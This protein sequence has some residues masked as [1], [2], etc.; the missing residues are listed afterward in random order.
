MI[1]YISTVFDI[2]FLR[3]MNCFPASN[4]MFSF[5][6]CKVGFLYEA[7]VGGYPFEIVVQV[8]SF[9]SIFIIV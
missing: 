1:G 8:V 6:F 9:A 7:Q 3:V 5:F 4:L 2:L